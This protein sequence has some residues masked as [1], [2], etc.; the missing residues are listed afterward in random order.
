MILVLKNLSS[1]L[2]INKKNSFRHSFDEAS[3]V[4]AILLISQIFL[5]FMQYILLGAAY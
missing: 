2:V 4:N 3:K 1:G 5:M